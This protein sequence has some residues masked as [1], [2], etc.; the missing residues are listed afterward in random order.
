MFVAC[1]V[2]SLELW[3]MLAFLD[4][5]LSSC[6]VQANA[7]HLR[8][9]LFPFA[10][11][12]KTI[13]L[14]LMGHCILLDHGVTSSIMFD[15]SCAVRFIC[16]PTM[17]TRVMNTS[18]K[19]AFNVCCSFDSIRYSHLVITDATSCILQCVTFSVISCSLWERIMCVTPCH[20][21]FCLS[22]CFCLLCKR[23]RSALKSINVILFSLTT[24]FMHSAGT[25]PK[26]TIQ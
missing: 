3:M 2:H 18:F 8:Q 4:R 21:S 20:R 14:L 10:D 17:S 26:W 25:L 12:D 7:P 1:Q 13:N 5:N 24:H 16:V 23:R 15:H 19:R 11:M 6:V 22:A 9:F